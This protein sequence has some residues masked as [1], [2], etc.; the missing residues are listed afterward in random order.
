MRRLKL[1]KAG[2]VEIFEL[3]EVT[4]DAAGDRRKREVLAGV[5]SP[6]RHDVIVDARVGVGVLAELIVIAAL[7]EQAVAEA[8]M[9][10]IVDCV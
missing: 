1:S 4:A 8:A 10:G 2:V 6:Q 9:Y 5:V 3:A 7:E